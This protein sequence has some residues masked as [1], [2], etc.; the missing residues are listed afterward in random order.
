MLNISVICFNF[1]LLELLLF[2]LASVV[3][4]F[5]CVAEPEPV[6]PKLYETWS[7]SR[8]YLFNTAVSLEDAS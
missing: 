1:F 4:L 5:V 7:R 6:E 3:Y 8:N 2:G